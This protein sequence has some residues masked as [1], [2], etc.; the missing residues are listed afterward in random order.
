MN[1]TIEIVVPVRPGD[2][3]RFP[4]TQEPE[5]IITTEVECPDGN[6]S[7]AYSKAYTESEAAVVIFKHDDFWFR[8]WESFEYQL[9][10]RIQRFP[11]IG[12][13]G[14]RSYAPNR[15]PAWWLQA[16]ARAGMIDGLNR[17]LVHHPAT[18]D[19]KAQIGEYI[20]TLFGPPGPAVV[21]DGCMIAVANC[22]LPGDGIRTYWNS[23]GIKW[24]DRSK[25]VAAFFDPEFTFHFYDIAF[26]LS[27]SKT[28]LEEAGQPACYVVLADVC[29]LGVGE[30]DNTWA[31]LSQQFASKYG[32]G[33]PLEAVFK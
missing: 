22:M 6:L 10:D 9:W 27:A 13:A 26:T 24:E 11:I 28:F 16:P 5:R 14:T 18:G 29:H 25:R 20:P 3:D 21:M 19:F 4:I 23:A 7:K 2:H 17:G 8:D 15:N 12:V 33:E 1:R 30:M 31:R 32:V